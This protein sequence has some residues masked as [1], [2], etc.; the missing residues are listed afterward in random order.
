MKQ[1]IERLVQLQELDRRL[2]RLRAQQQRI[3]E[4]LQER[5]APLTA[6]RQRLQESSEQLDNLTK[7]R[8]TKDQELA[9]QDDHIQKLRTRQGEIKTNKEYQAHIQELEGAKTQKSKVED[10]ILALMEQMDALRAQ[11]TEL[12]QSGTAAEEQFARDKAQIDGDNAAAL[13]ELH[14][15]EAER[16]ALAGRVD[17]DHLRHYE[18][19]RA[20]KK[21]LAI[22]PVA[23][24]NCAGCHMNI[25]PQLV[26]E[27]RRQDQILTC[28]YCHRILY[29]PA[30]ATTPVAAANS[31]TPAPS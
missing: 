16:A 2:T 13:K 29:W 4:L 14:D 19:L 28:S 8:R 22:V 25:P 24:G 6:L 1:K 20:G 31:Q 26:A 12:E 7:T 11:V 18:R 3:P 9:A 23:N 27:V 17:P 5:H 15:L 10:E 30:A 21:D